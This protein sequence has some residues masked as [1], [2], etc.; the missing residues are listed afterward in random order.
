MISLVH[1]PARCRSMRSRFAWAPELLLAAAVS[2]GTRGCGRLSNMARRSW[3]WRQDLVD[4]PLLDGGVKPRRPMSVSP[5]DLDVLE[6][7]ALAVQ[8]VLALPDR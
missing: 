3:V 4:L 2:C 8:D 1:L 6:A 5:A 7:A